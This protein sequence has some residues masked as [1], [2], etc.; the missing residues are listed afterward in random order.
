MNEF[1]NNNRKQNEAR[2]A[3]E[4]NTYEEF[5]PVELVDR[6][7]SGDFEAFGEIY[8][9]YLDQ[10][11]R[12]V[13]YRVRNK[14][15]AE[16]ITEEVFVKAWR[17]I[18]SCKGR[19]HTFLPWLYRIAH[20]QMVDDFRSRKREV[21]SVGIDDLA[22][23]SAPESRA[24]TGLEWRELS[25]LIAALPQ[26]QGQVITMKFIEGMDN[27]EIGRA[28]GKSQGAVRVLQMRALATLRQKLSGDR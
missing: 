28:M 25:E 10:V 23:V 15:T 14:M 22:D 27:R 12:Y 1:R 6:A 5:E 24:E 16:D 2:T 17:S 26:N 21:S 18:G 11:Y 3:G 8:S 20:N 4:A 13:F 9:M 7:A 19:G